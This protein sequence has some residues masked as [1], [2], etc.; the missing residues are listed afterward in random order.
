MAPAELAENLTA[1][2]RSKFNVPGPAADIIAKTP[3]ISARGLFSAANAAKK[4][5]NRPQFPYGT[6]LKSPSSF[7]PSL[8]L[9]RERLSQ[10]TRSCFTGKESAVK[11]PQKKLAV[12]KILC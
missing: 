2:V 10:G 12:K 8:S 3:M 4:R 7:Y 5:P 6:L 11:P 9:W 1:S